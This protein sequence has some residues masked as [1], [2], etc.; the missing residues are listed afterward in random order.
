MPELSGEAGKQYAQ[1]SA[2]LLKAV[3]GL[4]PRRLL[5]ANPHKW[6]GAVLAH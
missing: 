1:I 2:T 6:L 5:R 4:E 3:L